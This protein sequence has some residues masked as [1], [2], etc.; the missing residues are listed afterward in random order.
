MTEDLTAAYPEAAEYIWDAVDEHGEEWVL[1]NYY[2]QLYPL[3]VVMA[4]PEKAELPFFD[5]ETHETMSQTEL[6]EMYE[7]WGEYR[8]NLRTGTK[9]T[10]K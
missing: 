7:A 8:N 4:V 6:T 10:E 1:E 9:T 3:G 2:E 5:A